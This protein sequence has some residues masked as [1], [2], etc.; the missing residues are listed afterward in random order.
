MFQGV[1]G[2]DAGDAGVGRGYFALVGRLGCVVLVRN[3]GI[4]LVGWVM[5]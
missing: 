3:V 2:D 4:W 5:L 1:A